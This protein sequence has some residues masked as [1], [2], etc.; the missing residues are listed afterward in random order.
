MQLNQAPLSPGGGDGGLYGPY[1]A[2]SPAQKKKAA[3]SIEKYIEPDTRKA[4]D[5]A[6]EST[7]AAVKAFG[8]KDGEGWLT[9]GAL[10]AA[11]KTWNDQVKALLNRLSGEKASLRATNTLLG[12]SDIKVG[13]DTRRIPSALDGY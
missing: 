9:S 3:D 6:D 1:L 12:G 8:P 2:S 5:V 13:A 7:S 4:G 10:K 11:H